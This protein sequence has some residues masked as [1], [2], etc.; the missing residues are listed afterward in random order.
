[1]KITK[2]KS[3]NMYS[4]SLQAGVS[5]KFLCEHIR[6]GGKIQVTCGITKTDITVL[7]LR[8]CAAYK[9][10]KVNEEKRLYALLA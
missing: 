10:N 9:I 3:R 7:V 1:M 2:Y 4:H 6:G 8:Q 5:I